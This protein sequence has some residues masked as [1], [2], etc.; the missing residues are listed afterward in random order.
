MKKLSTGKPLDLNFMDLGASGVG[1]VLGGVVNK[2]LIKAM[3]TADPRSG[4]AI[5]IIGGYFLTR[6]KNR[7]FQLA[8][9]GLFNR[10]FSDGANAI[11]IGDEAISESL[12]LSDTM[13][14]E[15]AAELAA[16]ME[17]ELAGEMSGYM[18][19]NNGSI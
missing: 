5:N 12:D 7:M 13:E 10:G 15:L 14:A 17:A 4:S 2:G 9:L 11:G 1:T 18:A 3:P 19:D 16:E 8:G 6:T